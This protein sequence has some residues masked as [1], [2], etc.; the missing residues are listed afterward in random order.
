MVRASPAV[1]H[2]PPAVPMQ[3][4]RVVRAVPIVLENG[5]T[6][7]ATERRIAFEGK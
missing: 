7:S 3:R 4:S 2:D 1:G 6:E 5:Q